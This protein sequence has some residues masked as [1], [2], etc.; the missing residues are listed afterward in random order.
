MRRTL[1]FL[2]LAALVAVPVYLG[3][4]ESL[5]SPDRADA[6]DCVK[7]AGS[8][9]VVLVDCADSAAEYRVLGR[10]ENKTRIHAQIN[11]R[12]ICEPFPGTSSSF[13]RGEEGEAGYVLCLGAVR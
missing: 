12:T 8:Q 6:G 1:F 2:V 5:S 10:V 3:V 13:W 7:S 9:E 11:S 4:R